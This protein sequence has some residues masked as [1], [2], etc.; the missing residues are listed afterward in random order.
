[1]RLFPGIQATARIAR[2]LSIVKEAGESSLF[3]EG[4][5]NVF[6]LGLELLDTHHIS[7]LFL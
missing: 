3:L 4:W 1:M 5:N 7:L 2:F 6:F